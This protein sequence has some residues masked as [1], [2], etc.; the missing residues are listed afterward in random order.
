MMRLIRFC[1]VLCGSLIF[2]CCTIKEDRA[3]CP[4]RLFL[5]MSE[6]D[7]DV[8]EYAAVSLTG[9]DGFV[10]NDMIDNEFFSKGYFVDVPRGSLEAWVSYGAGEFGVGPEGI[11]VQ[12]GE[13]FP[14]IYM[15][16]SHIDAS[17]D[18]VRDKVVMN[19]NYCNITVCIYAGDEFPFRLVMRGNVNGY[20]ADG[21]LSEGDFSYEMEL[22]DDGSGDVSV[23]R[24]S[25]DSLRLEV[26][27]ETGVLRVFALGEYIAASGYDWK[28]RNLRD[29]T[30]SLDYSLTCVTVILEGWDNEYHYS[31]II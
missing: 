11:V 1:V 5:D 4:C 25:D 3:D 23:P 10:F 18:S 7:K 2:A 21:S 19:K 28:A 24:Q 16:H 12:P 26:S 31:V 6:V 22:G 8:V 27:D 20:C 15:Y 17:G 13:E 14:E 30:V 29:L 9:S